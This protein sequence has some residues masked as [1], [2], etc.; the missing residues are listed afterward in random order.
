M[1]L[2]WSRGDLAVMRIVVRPRSKLKQPECLSH[3]VVIAEVVI[4]SGH[5]GSVCPG[6]DQTGLGLGGLAFLSGLIRSL[7]LLHLLVAKSSENASNLLDL[8]ALQ[9]LGQLLTKLL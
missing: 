2:R 7:L 8:I 6:S 4:I 3:E 5:L 1:R 9:V